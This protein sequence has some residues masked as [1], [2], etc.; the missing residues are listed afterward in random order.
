MSNSQTW[1]IE[2]A[3]AAN[4]L[5]ASLSAMNF[6]DLQ[7]GLIPAEDA[8]GHNAMDSDFFALLKSGQH[9]D[10]SFLAGI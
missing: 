4:A 10:N 2:A 8:N 6:D 9:L 7:I 1:D 5:C 3:S